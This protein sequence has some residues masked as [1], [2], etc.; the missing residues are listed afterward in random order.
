MPVA[1]VGQ[2]DDDAPLAVGAAAEVDVAQRV[3]D[4]ARARLGEPLHDLRLGVELLA[5]VEQRHQ[6]RVA[7]DRGLERLRPVEVEHDA[8]AVAGLDHV[9]AAQRGIVDL[10]LRGA[11]TVGG[12]EE[13][14]R[15]ARRARDREARRRI[16]RRR[17]SA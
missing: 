8:R 1:A 17:S 6:H 11:E 10:A 15:D 5:L 12:V 16:R 14:E 3:L 4:V 2:V 13:V 9:D 7:L